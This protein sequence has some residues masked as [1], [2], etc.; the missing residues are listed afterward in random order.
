MKAKCPDCGKT[1]KSPQGVKVH[2]AHCMG[3]TLNPTHDPT[4]TDPSALETRV[5]R[6]VV[7][8][9]LS[10][11]IRRVKELAEDVGGL[12]ELKKTCE[13]LINPVLV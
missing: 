3:P 5:V 6:P 7:L 2:M 1:C 13:A 11:T 12:D 4:I 8:S 9:P 10:D